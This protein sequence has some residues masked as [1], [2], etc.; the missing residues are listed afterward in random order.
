MTVKVKDRGYDA[1]IKRLAK[2][3]P[4][5][6]SVG[7]HETEGDQ[8]HEAEGESESDLAIAELG[9]I[10]ELGLGV[11]QRSF[12]GGWVDENETENEARLRKLGEAVVMGKLRSPE[13]AM[14]R[15]GLFAVGSIQERIADGIAPDNT[16]AT[17]AAKG[18]STPLIAS[19]QLRAAI[20][21]KVQK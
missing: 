11:P 2:V 18:S 17:V 7:I 1:L 15:F 21:Y 9:E 16:D 3:P 5:Q 10:H 12:I 20:T 6:V 14:D 8:T 19:G 4:V 13:Q